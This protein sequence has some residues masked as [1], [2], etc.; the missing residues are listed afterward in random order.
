MQKSVHNE[1]RLPYKL[2]QSRASNHVHQIPFVSDAV[3]K[4]NSRRLCGPHLLGSCEY[5]YL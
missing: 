4:V 1:A 2:N 5:Q 3:D